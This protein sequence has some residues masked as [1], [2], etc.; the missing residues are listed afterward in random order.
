MSEAAELF[1]GLRANLEGQGVDVKTWKKEPESDPV[2]IEW[3]MGGDAGGGAVFE[4]ERAE[5]RTSVRGHVGGAALGGM[6]IR[7]Q[8]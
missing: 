7:P 8:F 1:Y 5:R 6:D 3:H 4:Y 2:H